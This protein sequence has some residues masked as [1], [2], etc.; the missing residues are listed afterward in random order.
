MSTTNP[1][2]EFYYTKADPYREII[3]TT[4]T[5]KYPKRTGDWKVLETWFNRG[6]C[7]SIGYRRV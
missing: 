1:T 4:K 6:D 7:E 3:L 2:W 5:C